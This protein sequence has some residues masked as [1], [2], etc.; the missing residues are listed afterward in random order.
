MFSHYCPG[1]GFWIPANSSI[2][3]K[4]RHLLRFPD[5]NFFWPICAGNNPRWLLQR[6]ATT[7]RGEFRPNC[8]LPNFGSPALVRVPEVCNPLSRRLS[9]EE[10]LLLG[11]ISLHELRPTDLPRKP[12]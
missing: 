9:T 8:F 5:L 1:D 12:P 3:G 11:P 2:T 4:L 7:M 10:L 6:S